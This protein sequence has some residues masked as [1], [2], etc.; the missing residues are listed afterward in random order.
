MADILKGDGQ[1]PSMENESS[2]SVR[3]VPFGWK[4]RTEDVDDDDRKM[5]PGNPKKRDRIR[6]PALFTKK[7]KKPSCSSTTTKTTTTNQK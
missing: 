4:K 3:A 1:S 7:K 2:S 6:K 5:T